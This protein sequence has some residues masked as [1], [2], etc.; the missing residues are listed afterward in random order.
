MHEKIEARRECV[1]SPRRLNHYASV[2]DI[3][4]ARGG[5]ARR[6]VTYVERT[7]FSLKPDVTTAIIFIL[8]TPCDFFFQPCLLFNSYGRSGE[9]P[10]DRLRTSVFRQI[11][12]ISRVM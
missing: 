12:K 3:S 8:Q 5:I 11:P 9:R 7:N 4:N 10:A 2:E 6:S 1:D